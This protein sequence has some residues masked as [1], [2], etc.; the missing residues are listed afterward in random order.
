M[1]F[2]FDAIVVF[3]FFVAAEGKP[4]MLQEIWMKLRSLGWSLD[5]LT[6]FP[7]IDHAY[8]KYIPQINQLQHIVDTCLHTDRMLW[9]ILPLQRQDKDDI[10]HKL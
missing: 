8:V 5:I 4:K 7:C 6:K 2:C 3:L 10:L 1:R 9:N